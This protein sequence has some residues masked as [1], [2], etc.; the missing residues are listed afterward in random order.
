VSAPARATCAR[1]RRASNRAM[2]TATRRASGALGGEGLS[3]DP[4]N[5]RGGSSDDDDLSAHTVRPAFCLIGSSSHVGVPPFSA[6]TDAKETD[7]GLVSKQA[8]EIDR[9]IE[10]ARVSYSSTSILK[11]TSGGRRKTPSLSRQPKLG[12]R[13]RR[14]WLP[15]ESAF[16]LSQQ[17]TFVY[18]L[19]KQRTNLLAVQYMSK[20]DAA[21]TKFVW[22][23]DLL[24]VDDWYRGILVRGQHVFLS[25]R[26]VAEGLYKH[27]P[28]E[29][30]DAVQVRSRR[31][32]E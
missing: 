1:R 16:R 15:S 8:D 5:P 31:P 19:N 13:H 20:G 21:E 10:T 22:G 7:M 28:A 27:G 4:P 6:T 9:R 30:R 32:P 26:T 2:L 24:H 23:D 14:N 29:L 18:T 3:G 12:E 11:A 25:E 17:K